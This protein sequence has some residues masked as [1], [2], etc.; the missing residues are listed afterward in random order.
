MKYLHEVLQTGRHYENVPCLPGNF[1][2]PES[3]ITC[4]CCGQVVHYRG[5]RCPCM[6]MER[7]YQNEAREVACDFHLREK[8]KD[9][10]YRT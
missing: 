5:P 10:L 4:T 2:T 8:I 6:H 9:G 7:W 3:T 1:E